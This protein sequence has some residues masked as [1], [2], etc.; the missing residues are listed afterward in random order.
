MIELCFM[1][2]LNI[3]SLQQ[4]NNAGFFIQKEDWKEG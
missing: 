1:N 2:C 4:I 3:N